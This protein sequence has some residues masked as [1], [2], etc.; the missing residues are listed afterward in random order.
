MLEHLLLFLVSV[1]LTPGIFFIF[2][3]FILPGFYTLRILPLPDFILHRWNFPGFYPFR[4][5]PLPDFILHGFY[6]SRLLSFPDFTLTVFYPFRI[7]SFRDFTFP[8]IGDSLN[9][10]SSNVRCL[11]LWILQSEISGYKD[12]GNRKSEFVVSI[13]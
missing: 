9:M 12:K 3:I 8:D 11:F 2:T 7:L 5:L 1:R 6:P 4:I 13:Q 10:I